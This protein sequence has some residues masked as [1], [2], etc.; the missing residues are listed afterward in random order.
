[1]DEQTRIQEAKD[2]LT[3]GGW[4][5]ND[6]GKVWEKI[7][8]KKVTQ[9][10]NFSLTT[11]NS[12]ELIK[13]ANIIKQDWEKIGVFV[14]IK[15]Y[16]SGD[17]QQN[18]IR[19]RKYD[20]LLFGEVIGRDLDLYAYWHS[21]QRN[22]PGYNVSMYTNSKADKLLEDARKVSDPIERNEKYQSF[23]SE[24]QKD[25]PAVFLYSPDFTYIT[26]NKVKGIDTEITTIPAERF[27]EVNKWYIE[28]NN[29]WKI[30]LSNNI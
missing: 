8:K 17:L 28:T 12:E 14:D 6:T 1:M 26:P 21:S 2:I 3:K 13:V 10:L 29:I 11:A 19:P 15:P 16:D 5:Y 24:V 18:I 23:Y 27:L 22:D 20:A 7:V 30:F 25:I 9:T 4:S